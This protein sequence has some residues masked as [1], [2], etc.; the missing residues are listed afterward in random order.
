MHTCSLVFYQLLK[1]FQLNY[2]AFSHQSQII[3]RVYCSTATTQSLEILEA[4]YLFCVL[5]E[6]ID[7]L[8]IAQA[9][10]RL[11]TSQGNGHIPLNSIVS[12]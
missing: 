12:C 6:H 2:F 4:V 10:K 1:Q 7:H 3:V 9:T 5:S 8:P 11:D